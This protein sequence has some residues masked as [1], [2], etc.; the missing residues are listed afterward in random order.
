MKKK[1]SNRLNALRHQSQRVIYFSHQKALDLPIRPSLDHHLSFLYQQQKMHAVEFNTEILISDYSIC[2]VKKKQ[3][4]CCFFRVSF[5]RGWFNRFTLV[6]NLNQWEYL[7]IKS[8]AY[9]LF[10]SSS[11]S[12]MIVFFWMQ[13][14]QSIC[15]YHFHYW[16][17]DN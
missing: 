2:H 12:Y 5:L 6:D 8:A 16:H 15:F 17:P 4:I 11:S 1:T 9:S 7:S 10:S 3:K 13:N 14:S